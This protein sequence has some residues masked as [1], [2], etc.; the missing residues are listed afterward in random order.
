MLFF[1]LSNMLGLRT[2]V[3]PLN[4]SGLILREIKDFWRVALLISIL[5]Y[6]EAETAADIHNKQDE[7]HRRKEKYIKVER[8]ITDLGNLVNDGCGICAFPITTTL[9][10]WGL[11][12]SYHCSIVLVYCFSSPDLDGVWKLKPVLD[13]KSI[14]GVMQVKSGGPLIGKWV[15]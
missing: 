12:C 8:S 10:V 1:V 13:G 11:S 5:S 7:L 6:P 2:H 3:S 15:H 4:I 14:M 9:R